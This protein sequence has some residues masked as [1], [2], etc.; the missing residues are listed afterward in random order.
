LF[1]DYKPMAFFGGLA[2]LLAAVSL[3]IG[4]IPIEEYVRTGLVLRFPL[5]ILAASLGILSALMFSVGM[6]LDTAARYH[7]EVFYALAKSN[8]SS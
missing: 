6:I 5:A 2:V 8:R 7:R 3:S 4:Y 1:K